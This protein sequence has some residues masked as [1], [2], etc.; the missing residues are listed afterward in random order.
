[1]HSH[2]VT[3]VRYL[4]EHMPVFQHVPREV[5]LRRIKYRR[6]YT[7]G[8]AQKF[9]LESEIAAMY[10]M[11]GA[12]CFLCGDTDAIPLAQIVAAPY[13][14]HLC[15]RCRAALTRIVE[16]HTTMASRLRA[17]TRLPMI[18]ELTDL[19]S[20]IEQETHYEHV[21][22]TRHADR[23]F[24]QAALWRNHAKRGPRPRSLSETDH[25]HHEAGA[26]ARGDEPPETQGDPL[27]RGTQH[28]GGRPKTL[29]P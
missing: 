22:I 24:E 9:D 29:V 8:Q 23:G 19:C 16:R 13:E 27:E 5:H 6:H 14:D 1:M 26:S 17:I 11:R 15:T 18:A 28:D 10:R 12:I 3:R 7:K 20:E 4:L 2:Q 21:R 25:R